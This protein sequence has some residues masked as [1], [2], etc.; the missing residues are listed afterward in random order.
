M[1]E[2]TVEAYEAAFDKERQNDYPE[3][4]AFESELGYAIDRD[5]LEA[6]AR[7]LACPVKV[8]PP[9]WQ[10]GRVLYA[11]AAKLLVDG[12]KGLI[13]DIGTAKG[14]SACM[15][16]HAVADSGRRDVHIVSLDIVDP[17]AKVLRNTVAEA[18]A[19]EA[20]SVHDVVAPF[21]PDAKVT[22]S[23][24]GSLSHLRRMMLRKEHVM[25]AF[26]DGKH[27]YG[28]VLS[29]IELLRQMQEKGDVIVF[30]D[31]QLPPVGQAVKR[32]EEMYDVRYLS[33]GARRAYAV[34]TKR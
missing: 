24:G 9:S 33:A 29:E 7:V 21:L 10:H 26:V 5:V 4:E 8:N 25:L 11:V 28:A 20:L 27:S 16:A 30:D 23:G 15:L 32:A 31:I 3:M 13:V 12:R 6:A 17:E 1:N 22:F 2:K 19:G 18:V 34:A 14:F